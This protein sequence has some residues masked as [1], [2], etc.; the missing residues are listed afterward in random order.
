[1]VVS[2]MNLDRYIPCGHILAAVVVVVATS[3]FPAAFSS[4]DIVGIP[5][6]PPQAEWYESVPETW[7][8]APEV[9][10]LLAGVCVD[11]GESVYGL[12][13]KFSQ[14]PNGFR[15]NWR[16][17]GWP[18][19]AM[20]SYYVE[21]S[22]PLADPRNN[23]VV[24][25]E[26]PR[27]PPF[28]KTGPSPALL[29]YLPIWPGF[30]ANTVIFTLVLGLITRSASGAARRFRARAGKCPSCGYCVRAASRCSEC[31]RSLDTG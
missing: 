10:L 14:P 18:F 2:R 24:G 12:G 17:S 29:P 21:E 13:D 16:E 19:R 6:Y 26:R 31:G 15:I 1:M 3:W 30:L 22:G 20:R 8:A 7:P 23:R 25:I 9:T 28:S 4:M 5:V 27:E 11:G